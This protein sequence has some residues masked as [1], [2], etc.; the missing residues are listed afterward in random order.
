MPSPEEDCGKG[1]RGG[2]DKEGGRMS[3]SFATVSFVLSRLFPLFLPY[4]TKNP[5]HTYIRKL[6]RTDYSTDYSAD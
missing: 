4:H 2:M 6:I 1:G 3:I 5:L